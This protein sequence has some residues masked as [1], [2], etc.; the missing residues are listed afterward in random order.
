MF[1]SFTDVTALVETKDG[2][3]NPDNLFADLRSHNV[4]RKPR[5]KNGGGVALVM[6]KALRGFLR[7][8]LD[9]SGLE[10]IFV[11]SIVLNLIFCVFYG[12]PCSINHS[13]PK[14]FAHFRILP[15][16]VISRMVLLGDFNTSGVN[17]RTRT[18]DST[19]GQSLLDA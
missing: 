1:C 13:L 5:N 9:I 10:I 19:R 18:S 7:S 12:P 11:E 17:W 4:F 6:K 14:L 15:H 3:D 16:T 8:D 2:P